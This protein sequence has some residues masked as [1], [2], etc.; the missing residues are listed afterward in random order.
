[1][2]DIVDE[3]VWLGVNTMDNHTD[4]VCQVARE[5]IVRLRQEVADLK[6][7]IHHLNEELLRR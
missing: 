5:E 2:K 4:E 7:R 3:L 1:M 6:S